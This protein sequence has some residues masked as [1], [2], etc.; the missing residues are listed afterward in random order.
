MCVCVHVTSLTTQNI[1]WS[2]KARVP[3]TV[4]E[5]LCRLYVDQF[6]PLGLLHSYVVKETGELKP[7]LSTVDHV[8][9]CTQDRD[10]GGG[11]EG[12]AYR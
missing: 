2:N 9:A 7:V 8:W 12:G 5:L 11:V 6:L 1:R 3:H 4:T 10:L